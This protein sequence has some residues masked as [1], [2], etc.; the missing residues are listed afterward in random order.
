MPLP[1][2]SCRT[3]PG[4][5]SPVAAVA[6]L[7]LAGCATPFLH[8]PAVEAQTVAVKEAWSKIDDA[9]YFQSLRAGF[10]TLEAEEDAALT[11]SLKAT[12]DRNLASYIA[13]SEAP[14]AT[15]PSPKRGVNKLCHDLD[16]RFADL[17]GTTALFT[18]PHASGSNSC[19]NVA[20]SDRLV[21]WSR[22]PNRI[23]G[24]RAAIPAAQREHTQAVE[25][26]ATQRAD[27]RNAQ[28]K[29]EDGKPPQ[30]PDVPLACDKVPAGWATSTTLAADIGANGLAG[31]PIA[32][33]D[34][35]VKACHRS[36]GTG[37]TAAIHALG[38]GGV[39]DTEIQAADPSI[40]QAIFQRNS[41]ARLNAAS[42]ATAGSL[43]TGEF[44]ALQKRIEEAKTDA[45]S[46]AFKAAV[47]DARKA[48]SDA[49]EA[50]K[51]VGA[52]KLATFLEEAL[53]ADLQAGVTTTDAAGEDDPEPSRTTKRVEAI[54]ALG[55]AGAKLRNALRLSDPGNRVS[56][57]LI[58]LAAQRQRIDMLRLAAA[59]ETDRLAVLDAELLGASTELALLAEARLFLMKITPTNE[60]IV[61]L[62]DGSQRLAGLSAVNRVGLAWSE[63]RIPMNMARL[64]NIYLNR[65]YRINMAQKTS[66]NWRG[67]IKPAIDQM[68]AAGP[69]GIR[70]EAIANLFGQLGIAGMIAAK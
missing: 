12:R 66:E 70:A 41:E 1:K 3:F 51:L 49:P 44:K 19:P 54:I 5:F 16:R 40:V 46:E 62:K 69:A 17:V 31:Y 11:R 20:S 67:L 42:S 56:P 23:S 43:L 64:R 63:G 59:R 7:A 8:D 27:W 18:P 24:L 58:A 4:L 28:P 60:G 48:L 57:L 34:A 35:V 37:L 29:G 14:N 39:L 53:K 65:N 47:E 10:T 68:V 9:A 52:E 50:A 13:P 25:I 61:T 26:F 32:E 15:L 6:S 33:Y 22:L 21:T 45:N 38:P 30:G 55:D 2:T 36:N